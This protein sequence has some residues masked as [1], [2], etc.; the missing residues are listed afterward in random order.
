M[1]SHCNRGDPSYTHQLTTV[2]ESDLERNL[3]GR[4]SSGSDERQ[5]VAG[6]GTSNASIPPDTQTF[7]SLGPLKFTSEVTEA[8]LEVN[9]SLLS[10]D[11][12]MPSLGQT[13][14]SPDSSTI[15]EKTQGS[16]EGSACAWD[17]D[18]STS[19]KNDASTDVERETPKP[20]RQLSRISPETEEILNSDLD[21]LTAASV[22]YP[23]KPPPL[24]PP[25]RTLSDLSFATADASSHPDA[26]E[27]AALDAE[28]ATLDR[29]LSA[30][31]PLP[32]ANI[33][34]EDRLWRERLRYGRYS[35][36][37]RVMYKGDGVL[38]RGCRDPFD[39]RL[40]RKNGGE[41]SPQVSPK[42]KSVMVKDE[43][44]EE[45]G[46]Y[47]ARVFWGNPATANEE[48]RDG[49]MAVSPRTRTCGRGRE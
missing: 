6:D 21:T 23:P 2:N 47:G 49:E 30:Y 48:D 7:R 34:T 35:E 14:T 37:D 1:A 44:D 24:S 41:E 20:L 38:A 25:F 27:L 42:S 17:D 18:G 22:P 8:E 45:E 4:A 12:F 3:T 9:S 32:G 29:E 36:R 43:Q 40:S 16:E 15:P 33:Q 11:A 28:S 31:E 10:N 46:S 5:S 19:N 13:S 26:A 39:G